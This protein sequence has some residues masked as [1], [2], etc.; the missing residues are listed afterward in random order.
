MAAASAEAR[1]E[2]WAVQGE[3]VTRRLTAAELAALGAVVERGGRV[4]AVPRGVRDVTLRSLVAEGLLREDGGAWEATARGR[5]ALA[6]PRPHRSAPT[7]DEV[8]AAWERARSGKEGHGRVPPAMRV[9]PYARSFYQ[10]VIE[11]AD[12]ADRNRR[13]KGRRS[14][15]R[16]YTTH[17]RRAIRV[18]KLWLRFGEWP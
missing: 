9:Y 5:S 6:D 8:N 17:E 11:Q 4:T 3:P 12:V 1:V 18:T 14:I 16:P 13:S 2:A 10:G 15:Y 7:L